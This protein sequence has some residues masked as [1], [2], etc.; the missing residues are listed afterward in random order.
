[1]TG[2]PTAPVS[3]AE[4][5]AEAALAVPGVAGLHG[6]EFGTIATY[7]PGRRITGVQINA[8]SCAVHLI[9]RYPA[10]LF[11][12][13]ERV[14]TAVRSIVGIPVDVTIEDI[15]DETGPEL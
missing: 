9:L 8:D 12:T 1:M 5:A 15:T 2:S 3:A 10:D 4:R 13:A 7:L 14:R 6:G 11:E